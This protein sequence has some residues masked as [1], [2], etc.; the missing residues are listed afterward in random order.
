MTDQ[1]VAIHIARYRERKNQ[2]MVERL[3]HKYSSFG[4]TGS[5][6]LDKREYTGNKTEFYSRCIH[7]FVPSHPPHKD[8][9]LNWVKYPALC[10]KCGKWSK[11]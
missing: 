1:E 9:N 7:N 6:I 3:E 4:Y 10:S 11:E 8:V 2:E 5:N